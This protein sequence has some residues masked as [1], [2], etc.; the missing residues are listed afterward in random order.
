MNEGKIIQWYPG[1]MAKTK[2]EISTIISNVDIV[3]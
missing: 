2:K 3:I 1:H